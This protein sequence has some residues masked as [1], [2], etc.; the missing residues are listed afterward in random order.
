VI[1]GHGEPQANNQVIGLIQTILL[2]RIH[3]IGNRD[4]I[5]RDRIN[6]DNRDNRDNKDNKDNKDL[7]LEGLAG[8]EIGAI[9]DLKIDDY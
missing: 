3:G 5:S 2:N 1:K 6:R 8:I 7:C 9:N 4:K